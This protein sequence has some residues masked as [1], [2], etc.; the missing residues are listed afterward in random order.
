MFRI[1]PT[2]IVAHPRD[3]IGTFGCYDRWKEA[4]AEFNRGV[5]K[6]EAMN[7]EMLENL[8]DLAFLV[9]NLE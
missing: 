6:N 5:I 3:F 7:Q 9:G 4:F 2:G 8:E 1:L